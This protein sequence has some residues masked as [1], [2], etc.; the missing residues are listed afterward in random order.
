MLVLNNVKKSF[1]ENRMRV[2]AL[3]GISYEFP[4]RGLVCIVGRSGSGKSTLLKILAGL[5][6]ASEGEVLFHG[7]N[8]T[9][10]SEVRRTKYRRDC[11]GLVFQ[12]QNFFPAL[13][14]R[15]NVGF[16]GEAD[17][18]LA[19]RLGIRDLLDRKVSELSGGQL[20][21]ATVMRTLLQN[22]GVVLAD[23]PTG[24]LDEVTGQ[25]IFALFKEISKEKLVIIVTHDTESAEKFADEIIRLRSGRISEV[26][27]AAEREAGLTDALPQPAPKKFP[28]LNKWGVL[29]F[30]RN[31]VKII[32][33]IVVCFLSAIGVI[34]SVISNYSG[35]KWAQ[36]R[37]L[38]S[39]AEKYPYVIAGEH[40][41][42]DEPEKY[43]GNRDLMRYILAHFTVLPAFG[44]FAVTESTE[45]AAPFR[46]RARTEASPLGA[47][48]F[49]LNYSEFKLEGKFTGTFDENARKVGGAVY[50]DCVLHDDGTEKPMHEYTLDDL[51]SLAGKTFKLY[52]AMKGVPVSEVPALVCRGVLERDKKLN[53]ETR[54][55][56]GLEN[57][58]I[59]A[60]ED[61]GYEIDYVMLSKEC[62]GSSFLHLYGYLNFNGMLDT[63]CISHSIRDVP[64]MPTIKAMEDKTEGFQYAMKIV[65]PCLLAVYAAV[66][67]V[68]TYIELRK[69]KQ[70][71]QLLRTLGVSRTRIFASLLL[72]LLLTFAPLVLATLIT[73]FPVTAI[74]NAVYGV[75][76]NTTTIPFFYL[77]PAGFLWAA[78]LLIA[79]LIPIVLVALCSTGGRNFAKE[80]RAE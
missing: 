8:V 18:A 38:S 57:P 76:Y 61:S 39:N 56:I 2:D 1:T 45:T 11:V 14:V 20:Q 68:I 60:T 50:Y 23:E 33:C 25:E 69:K 30:W 46:Y 49:Y 12:E 52:A 17:E 22:P 40:V 9:A 48:G 72:G 80:I 41:E 16:Y 73:I 79:G 70:E 62:G 65:S 71:I 35:S 6:R 34:L 7:E 21:R 44:D 67:A 29:A 5:D 54:Y 4:K 37:V 53:A 74:M 75:P 55:M 59:A 10:M 26:T 3:K 64:P 24:A 58:Y 51:D 47:D 32:L 19:E 42:R 63:N 13:T 77:R 78:L 28:R 31:K 15:E 66:P 43:L 36:G 27:G